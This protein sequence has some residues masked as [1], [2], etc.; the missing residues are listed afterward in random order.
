MSTALLNSTLSAFITQY[1]HIQ[2]ITITVLFFDILHIIVYF[3]YYSTFSIL[4]YILHII[5]ILQIIVPG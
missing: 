4:L 3:A 5:Y 1:I 2:M